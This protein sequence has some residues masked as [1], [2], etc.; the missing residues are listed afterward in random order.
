[1]ATI[2]FTNSSNFEKSKKAAEWTGESRKAVEVSRGRRWKGAYSS[3]IKWWSPL[4]GWS[5]DPDYIRTDGGSDH[6]DKDLSRSE[7][8]LEAKQPRS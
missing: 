5:S 2:I 4:F 6:S 1:M 7:A 8:D 3:S